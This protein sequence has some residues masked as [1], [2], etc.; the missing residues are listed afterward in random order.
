MDKIDFIDFIDL[1]DA[2]RPGHSA[3]K[4]RHHLDGIISDL[5]LETAKRRSE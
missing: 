3:D 2:G 1:I 5:P 4:S